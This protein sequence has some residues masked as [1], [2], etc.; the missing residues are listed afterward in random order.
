MPKRRDFIEDVNRDPARS[1]NPGWIVFLTRNA[2]GRDVE[3]ASKPSFKSPA[4]T[5]RYLVSFGWVLKSILV[6]YAEHWLSQAF[7]QLLPVN[8]L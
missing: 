8:Y 7:M 1:S 4:S 6:R 5:Q 3:G 2:R